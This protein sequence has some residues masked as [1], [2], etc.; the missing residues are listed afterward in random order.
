MLKCEYWGS[1]AEL[2]VKIGNEKFLFMNNW[3]WRP[4][5]V[6]VKRC[7]SMNISVVRRGRGWHGRFL[8]NYG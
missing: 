2:L 6:I 3:V 4:I 7:E 5:N 1:C 8:R